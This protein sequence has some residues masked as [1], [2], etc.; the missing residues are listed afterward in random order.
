FLGAISPFICDSICDITVVLNVGL[1]LFSLR[2]DLTLLLKERIML[3]HLHLT[4]FEVFALWAVL[5]VSILGLLYALFL[6]NQILGEDQGT[7]LMQEVW[8]AIK[9]GAN[10]YLGKQLRTILPFI[11]ALTV[12]LFLSVYIVPPSREAVE[13]FPNLNEDQLRVW[14]GIG[15]AVAFVMG[16]VFS[17]AIGQI[18]M[19]MAVEANV[20]VAAEAR[21]SFG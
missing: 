18:G 20:R 8:N 10:A 14:M 15:R 3:H 1:N 12:L 19:R 5:G 17:L 7:P 4:A 13:R 9:A 11:V 21:N 16:A 6:R 2:L